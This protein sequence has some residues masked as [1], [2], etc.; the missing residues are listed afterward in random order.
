MCKNGESVWFKRNTVDG[1]EIWRSPVEVG[2]G[3][4]MIYLVSKNIQ[5]GVSNGIS[6]PSTVL[7]VSSACPMGFR[8]LCIQTSPFQHSCRW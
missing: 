5:T 8:D 4:P 6:E 1:S 2:S 3:H 7:A